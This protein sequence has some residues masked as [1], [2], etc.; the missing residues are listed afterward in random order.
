M[1]PASIFPETSVV[2]ALKFVTHKHTL[3]Q[4][5]QNATVKKYSGYS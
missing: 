5:T 1:K 4:F 3:D 2:I